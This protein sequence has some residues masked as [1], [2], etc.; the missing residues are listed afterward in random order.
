MANRIKELRKS[1]N[2]TLKQLSAK[3]GIS[4]SSL[5]A[6]EKN[7][8]EK[9][10]RS[11]KIDKWVQLAD[12]F[13]VPVPYLQGISDVKTHAKN[14]GYKIIEDATSIG[15]AISTIYLLL[16]YMNNHPNMT[17]IPRKLLSGIE[18]SKKAYGALLNTSMYLEWLP[19]NQ[20][21]D[22]A[23]Q[24]SSTVARKHKDDLDYVV[25]IRT[26]ENLCLEFLAEVSRMVNDNNVTNKSII[27]GAI[28]GIDTA[29]TVL[30][31]RTFGENNTSFPKKVDRNLYDELVQIFENAK[32][33]IKSLSEHYK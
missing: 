22:F 32:N 27:N 31:M 4:V 29:L 12:F 18:L 3:T 26:I 16:I 20:I 2:L 17:K 25:S 5:S 8:G 21:E 28:E 23:K 7:E 19:E 9:G 14:Y 13:D 11:P 33:Q 1:K 24:I 15:D 30:D 10:Y 6:Y